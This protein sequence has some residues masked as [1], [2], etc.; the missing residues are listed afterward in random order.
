MPLRTR[1]YTFGMK[2][3]VSIPDEIFER[4]ERLARQTKQSRSRI[5]S[6]ALSEYLAR[7][8]P[9][10]ITRAADR[11]CSHIGDAD[12]SFATSASHRIL[13]RNQW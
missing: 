2:T 10:E 1:G 13:A 5:Y 3:A 12:D 9:D 6:D 11:A 8:S 4:T 7:H